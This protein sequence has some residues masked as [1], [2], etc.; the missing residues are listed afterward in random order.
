[1]MLG[2]G[3]DTFTVSSTLKPGADVSTGIP[4]LHGGITAIH[5]G[6]N[7]LLQVSDAFGV[8]RVDGGANTQVTRTDGLAWVSYGFAVGQTILYDGVLAGVI[9][10]AAP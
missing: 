4:A 10:S 1:V 2:E 7:S 8:A 5:G 6:G 3:N 9:T